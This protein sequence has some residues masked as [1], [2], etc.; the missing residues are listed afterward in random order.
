MLVMH[1]VL[2]VIVEHSVMQIIV[3]QLMNHVAQHKMGNGVEQT[4]LVQEIIQTVAKANLE[5]NGVL[6]PIMVLRRL[7]AISIMNIAV[8][9]QMVPGVLQYHRLVLEHVI[10]MLLLLMTNLAVLV[11]AACG[12]LVKAPTNVKIVHQLQSNAVK[13]SQIIHIVQL[14]ALIQDVIQIHLILSM[15][16]VAQ[17]IISFGAIILILVIRHWQR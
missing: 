14:V 15:K 9:K 3:Q 1:A 6:Q 12:A 4:T 10:L 8:L 13:M 5:D 7:C 17:I 2:Q 11:T 16:Y